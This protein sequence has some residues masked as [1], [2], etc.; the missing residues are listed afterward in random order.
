MEPVSYAISMHSVGGVIEGTVKEEQE[1]RLAGIWL[2]FITRIIDKGHDIL[3]MAWSAIKTVCERLYS[4]DYEKFTKL[5]Y[6][7]IPKLFIKVLEKQSQ[8]T[9]VQKIE[10]VLK[11]TQHLPSSDKERIESYIRKSQPNFMS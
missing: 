3:P 9:K 1:M 6:E 7:R 5:I 8:L 11:F 10:L 4:T 2:S